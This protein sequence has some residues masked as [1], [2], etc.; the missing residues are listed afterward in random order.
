MEYINTKIFI[1]ISINYLTNEHYYSIISL[2]R[3]KQQQTI[4]WRNEYAV[5]QGEAR[6]RPETKN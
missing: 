5:L 6:I 3:R 1:K 2:Q 4:T